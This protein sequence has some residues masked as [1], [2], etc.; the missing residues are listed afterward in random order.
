M[1]TFVCSKIAILLLN[2]EIRENKS[3]DIGW[4]Y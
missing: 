4:R 2:E 1:I 3:W